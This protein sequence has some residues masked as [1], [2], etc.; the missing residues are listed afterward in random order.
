M[1]L[2]SV[3]LMQLIHELGPELLNIVPDKETAGL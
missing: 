2:I 1:Q 3:S